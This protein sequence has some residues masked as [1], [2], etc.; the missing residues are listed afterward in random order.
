MKDDPSRCPSGRPLAAADPPAAGQAR[1]SPGEG[2][3]PAAGARRGRGEERGLRAAGDRADAGGLRVAAQGDRRGRRR[4]HDLRGAADRRTVATRRSARC[5]TRARDADYDAH[6]Q[7]ARDRRADSA[8]SR[9]RRREPKRRAQ[10][11]RLKAAL[12]QVVAIDFFGANGR[13]H[14]GGLLAEL[15]DAS[16]SQTMATQPKQPS[17]HDRRVGEPEADGSG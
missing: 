1:L 16:R 4:G 7:G 14:V 9:R 12:A 2:L 8:T 15:E 11:A 13:E 3:A 6:R 17:S 5:S 10:L